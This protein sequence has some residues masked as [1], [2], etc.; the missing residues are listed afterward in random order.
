[1]HAEINDSPSTLHQYLG[2][3]TTRKRF[4]LLHIP[5]S[6][7]RPL[8]KIVSIIETTSTLVVGR[9]TLKTSYNGKS[10]R[11]LAVISQ[12]CTVSLPDYLMTIKPV[13]K[14]SA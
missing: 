12:T 10:H 13:T 1:M 9:L 7:F 14:S 5:T 11:M 6:A 8:N 2:S 4:E 3:A